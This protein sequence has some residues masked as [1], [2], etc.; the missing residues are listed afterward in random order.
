[1]PKKI[2]VLNG[3]NLNMLGVRE[4]G[5]YGEK[6]LEEIHREIEEKARSL[7]V[8]IEFMQSNS[9]GELVTFIQQGRGRLDGIIVNAGAYTH[10]SLAIRDSIA[11]SE[12]PAVE[13]HISNIFKREDFRHKSVIAPVCIGQISGFGSYSYILALEALLH[14]E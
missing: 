8:E 1:M 3:P 7:A 5:V 13:V 14:R 9:E 10:Y 4:T 12:L 11:A 2:A 6:T